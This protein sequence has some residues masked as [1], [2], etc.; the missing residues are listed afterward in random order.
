MDRFLKNQC[1]VLIAGPTGVGKS[2][3]LSK[4]ALLGLKNS[5]M[6]AKITQEFKAEYFNMTGNIDV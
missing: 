4:Y 5:D 6:E 3:L 2:K 1:N